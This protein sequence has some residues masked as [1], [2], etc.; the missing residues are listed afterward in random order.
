MTGFHV[1]AEGCRFPEGPVVAGDGSLWWVEIEGGCFGTVGPDG[2]VRRVPVGGRPNGAALG[3]DGWLWYCDQTGALRRFDPR[4]EIVE[5][6]LTEIDGIVLGKPND[7][8]FDGQHNLLFTCSNDAREQ[9]VGYI[10][11]LG[12]DGRAERIAENLYFPN[13]LALAADGCFILAETYR[14]RVLK[15]YW[16][17]RARRLTALVPFAETGGP[18]GPDGVAWLPDGR[19]AVAVFGLGRVDLLD[20]HGRRTDS[21]DPGGA[22]P[23]NCCVDPDAPNTL[24]VT[25]T[26]TG[27]VLALSMA[28]YDSGP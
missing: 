24:I 18:I 27:R 28:L 13:G 14:Q 23:T 12:A 3:P 4:R 15:G 9:P 1:L 21:L 25:E 6:L 11:C 20:R 7:L 22:R 5:T 16:D 8:V 2:A 10:G 19:L 26:E 17:P